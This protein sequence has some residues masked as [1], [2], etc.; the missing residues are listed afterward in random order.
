MIQTSE[1]QLRD[2]IK[3]TDEIRV[4]KRN[5][6]RGTVVPV[7]YQIPGTQAQTA[8]NFTTPFFVADRNYE[9]IE[10]AERHQVAGSDG[11][12]VTIMLNKVPSGTAP[13][14]GTNVLTATLSLKTTADTIQYGT[15][16]TTLPNFT[17]ARGDSL[18]VVSAGTLTA[19]QGV[20]VSVLLKA[21]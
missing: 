4:L 17:L 21:I 13:A 8:A 9:V 11:S 1:L 10:F 19:L 16:T 14:S 12:P 15:I 2:L 5:G 20:T 7:S 18:S 6:Y 3:D